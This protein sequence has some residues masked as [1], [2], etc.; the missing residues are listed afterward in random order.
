MSGPHFCHVFSS[1]ETGGAELRTVTLM[2]ALG[3][4]VRHTIIPVNGSHGAA[5]RIASN[6]A[7]DVR[8]APPGKGSLFYGAALGRALAALRPDLVLTYNW[9]AIDAVVGSALYRV[10]PVIHG[11]D[12]FGRDEAAALKQ[13][14]VLAR[15][16]IL[17]AAHRTIVPSRVLFEIALNRYHVPRRRLLYIPNGVD[18]GRF[19]PRRSVAWRR[20]H[21]IPDDAVVCGAV[22][23][24]RP[25][26]HFGLLIAAWDRVVQRRADVW[27]AIAGDGPCAAELR[28]A[29]ARTSNPSRVV[30]A[31]PLKEPVPFYQS[32][33]I[34]ALSSLTEQMPLSVLEA[35]ACGLPV[36]STDVGDVRHML[37]EAAVS[38]VTLVPSDNVDAYASALSVIVEDRERR[39][40]LGESNHRRCLETYTLSGMVDAYTRTFETAIGRSF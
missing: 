17:R 9:G 34:F 38:G 24:L 30:F 31:G 19:H 6:V 23:A 26:K 36:L 7:V 22:G 8:P 2:N 11:E 40:R 4:R 35:M 20:E 29:A 25:E 14:R 13:R 39:A 5:D 12:G 18:Q 21:H 10:A 37:G 33:D 28:D 1:F 16:L 27:L 3:E 32:L 15:R